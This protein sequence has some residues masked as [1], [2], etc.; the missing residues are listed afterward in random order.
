M[1]TQST[2]LQIPLPASLKKEAKAVVKEQGF[3]SL[4]DFIRL[5]LTKLVHREISINIGPKEEYVTLSPAAKK[6]YAKV[7]EEIKMG[8]NVTKTKNVEELLQLLHS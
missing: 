1:S 5:V 3:S 7:V 8:K 2:T 6:R 4:Q